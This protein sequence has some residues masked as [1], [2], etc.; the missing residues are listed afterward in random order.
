SVLVMD[1]TS[2]VWTTLFSWLAFA[3]LPSAAT[4]AGAPLIVAAGLVIAW[5]E[6]RLHHDALLAAEAE[7][8]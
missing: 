1:Y 5:R 2:L 4:W 8:R 6:H 3:Q 7:A